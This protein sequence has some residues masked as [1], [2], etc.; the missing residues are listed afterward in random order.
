[1]RLVIISI[2]LFVCLLCSGQSTELRSSSSTSK[3]YVD[4]QIDWLKIYLEAEVRAQKAAVEKVA[5]E[6]AARFEGQNE[7]RG[8]F[9]DQAAKFVTRSELWSAFIGLAGLMLA[10]MKYMKETNKPLK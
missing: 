3:E 8:Q 5:T 2:L 4:N 7:W 1:M 10:G 9:K 6:T